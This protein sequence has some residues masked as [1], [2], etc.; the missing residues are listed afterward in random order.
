MIEKMKL[1]QISKRMH[2]HSNAR[3]GA[4]T[5]QCHECKMGV[6]KAKPGNKPGN[7][8]LLKLV[9]MMLYKGFKASFNRPQPK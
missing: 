6:S 1:A 4:L 9:E 2:Q 5:V 3:G 7:D 8:C